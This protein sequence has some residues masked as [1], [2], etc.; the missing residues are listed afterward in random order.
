MPTGRYRSNSF[1]SPSSS[2]FVR[3]THQDSPVETEILSVTTE[4]GT[5]KPNR[6]TRRTCARI[7]GI[8]GLA[9]LVM[10][11]YVPP[12]YSSTLDCQRVYAGPPPSFGG[13]PAVDETENS[14]VS[15]TGDHIP[16]HW[17]LEI[18]CGPK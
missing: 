12:V 14:Y 18:E 1:T 6:S 3:L 5:M 11:L 4:G 7:L 13:D 10:P 15:R 16:S 9:A 2:A 8:V 17:L